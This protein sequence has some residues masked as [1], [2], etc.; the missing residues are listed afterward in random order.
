MAD[1]EDLNER[2]VGCVDESTSSNC[3]PLRT[4]VAGAASALLRAD[5]SRPVREILPVPNR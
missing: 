3:Q 1:M 5:V 4:P 2:V